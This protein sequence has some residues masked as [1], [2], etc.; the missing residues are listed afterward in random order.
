MAN[1]ASVEK[2][3]HSDDGNFQYVFNLAAETKYSQSDEVRIAMLQEGGFGVIVANHPHSM[4]VYKVYRERV[5][6]VA[7]NC[8]KQAAKT[9]VS[10]FIHFS[11]AQVYDCDK[12]SH[13]GWLEWL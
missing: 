5:L 6:T 8:A 1:A 7:V 3:F 2:A 10:R 11:T 12:V 9:K 13:E 4:Y